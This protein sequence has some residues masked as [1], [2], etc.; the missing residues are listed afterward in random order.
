MEAEKFGD[1]RIEK[2]H[3]QVLWMLRLAIF[4]AARIN[5][6]A[7]LRTGDVLVHRDDDGEFPYLYFRADAVKAKAGEDRSRKVPLHPALYDEKHPK[8]IGNFVAYAD[9]SETEHIFGA[10][11]DQRGQRARG[12]LVSI[13]RLHPRARDEAGHYAEEWEAG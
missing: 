7:S 12:W 9:A 8:F 2:R 5:E 4:T 3:M 6:V 13:P 11:A 1:T 10:F